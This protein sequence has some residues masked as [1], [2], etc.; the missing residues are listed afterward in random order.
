MNSIVLSTNEI[1][2]YVKVQDGLFGSKMGPIIIF[3]GYK[4]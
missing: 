1:K 2:P 3:G 4:F